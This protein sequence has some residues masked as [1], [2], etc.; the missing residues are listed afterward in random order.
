MNNFLTRRRFL[1]G[2][3]LTASTLG[4]AGCDALVENGNVQSVIKM[5]ESLTMRTQRFLIGDTALAREFS[6]SEISPTFRANGTS[7]P[8][9]AEYQSLLASHFAQW[10]LHVGGLVERPASISLAALKAMPARTQITRHDCV[11]GWSAIGQWTGVPLGDVLRAAGLKKDARYIAFHCADEYEKTLDGSGWYYE[12]IDLVD[13]F[14][15]Q[16]ILA[17]AMNGRDLEVP[18]GAPLRLR[19]ER[20]LGYKQAKYVMRIEAVA[21]LKN[22]YGGNGGFWE[23]RG[24]EWYAGI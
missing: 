1:I 18:H 3:T 10:Q 20:Q 16:T 14:H 4:L 6:V 2:S 23:D 12:S 21:D 24:Y 9:G 17:Y 11:E 19:V 7:M 8:D 13:A 15:P 22:L 5:A